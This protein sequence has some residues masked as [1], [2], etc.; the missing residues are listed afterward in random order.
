MSVHSKSAFVADAYQKDRSRGFRGT[1]L[2]DAGSLA[3]KQSYRRYAVGLG[4]EK[5]T[6]DVRSKRDIAP[7]CT[8]DYDEKVP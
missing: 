2:P 4:E 5:R 6:G 7:L 3:F 8:S 1:C